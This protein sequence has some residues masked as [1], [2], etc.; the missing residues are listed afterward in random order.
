MAKLNKKLHIHSSHGEQTVNLYT[1]K[2]ELIIHPGEVY[3]VIQFPDFE[4]GN[5]VV[6]YYTT[7]DDKFSS[8]RLNKTINKDDKTV[9]VVNQ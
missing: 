2:E 8:D 5:T 7:T 4:N 3:G 9:Y 6:A 1:T